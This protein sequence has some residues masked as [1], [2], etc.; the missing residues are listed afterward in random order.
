MACMGKK[1]KATT[2]K[3]KRHRHVWKMQKERQE[4]C[5]KTGI[6]GMLMGDMD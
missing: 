6:R 3:K 1:G 4:R 2:S 5:G